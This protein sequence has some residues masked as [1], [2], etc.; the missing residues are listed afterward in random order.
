MENGSSEDDEQPLAA[1]AA[2]PAQGTLNAFVRKQAAE[3]K[4]AGKAAAAAKPKPKPKPARKRAVAPDS[5]EARRPAAAGSGEVRHV[6]PTVVQPPRHRKLRQCS[7]GE[8]CL[9]LL[10][11]AAEDE[12]LVDLAGSSD[13]EA[14]AGGTQD[15]PSVRATGAGQLRKMEVTVGCIPLCLLCGCDAETRSG[16]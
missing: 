12:E 5:G 16:V 7:T 14:A 8:A 3:P 13:E 2:K 4:S 6:L 1:R 10:Q 15:P 11:S 9:G